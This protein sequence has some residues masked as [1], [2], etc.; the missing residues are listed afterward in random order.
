MEGT[1]L[2][3]RASGRTVFHRSR[4]LLPPSARNTRF[5]YPRFLLTLFCLVPSIYAPELFL[6]FP[7]LRDVR[8]CFSH[9]QIPT[10]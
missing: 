1:R 9:W 10:L 2:R 5:C 7:L 3:P 8:C 4:S 6:S